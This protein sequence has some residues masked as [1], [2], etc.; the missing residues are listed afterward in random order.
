[1][2][3]CR[4]HFKRAPQQFDSVKATSRLPVKL[5]PPPSEALRPRRHACRGGGPAS[6]RRPGRAQAGFTLVELVVVILLVTLLGSFTVGRFMDR[7]PAAL[8]ATADRLVSSLRLAQVTALTQRRTVCLTF[9]QSPAALQVGVV[10]AAGSDDCSAATLIEPPGGGAWLGDT[11]H[12]ALNSSQG[13]R[14]AADGTPLDSNGGPL[15][16]PREL[17]VSG[18]GPRG[19]AGIFIEPGSGHVRVQ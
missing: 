18:A 11:G 2:T 9:T 15:T 5:H 14:F 19:S 1:M 6:A 7:E 12:L 8:Q 13:L 10:A 3:S 17:R 16:S 4:S